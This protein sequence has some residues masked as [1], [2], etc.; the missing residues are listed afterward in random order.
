MNTGLGD[1]LQSMTARHPDVQQTA[2]QGKPPPLEPSISSSN[3]NQ[4][5]RGHRAAA[6]SMNL[7]NLK[8][9]FASGGQAEGS[10]RTASAGGA[11]GGLSSSDNASG[12]GGVDLDRVQQKGKEFMKNAGVFGSKAGAGAKGLLAKGRSRFGGSVRGKEA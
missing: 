7:S 3:T 8:N 11:P 6:P 4:W 10:G 1:W 12:S 9:R 5:K 2:E